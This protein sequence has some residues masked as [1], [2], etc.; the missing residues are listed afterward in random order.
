MNISMPFILE[1]LYQNVLDAKDWTM[2]MERLKNK[3]QYEEND[4]MYSSVVEAQDALFTKEIEWKR[5]S[6]A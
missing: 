6:V 5:S 3:K 2:T 4:S 1:F